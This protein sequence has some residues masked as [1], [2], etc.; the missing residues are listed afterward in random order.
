MGA[1]AAR[2]LH[3][4]GCGLDDGGIV[5]R[6]LAG[7]K[8]FVSETSRPLLGPIQLPVKSVP[9]TLSRQVKWLGREHYHRLPSGAEVGNIQ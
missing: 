2:Y 4:P 1:G 6:L 7:A 8:G 5:V 9:G 3:S